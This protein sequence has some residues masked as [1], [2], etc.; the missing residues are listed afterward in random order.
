MSEYGKLLEDLEQLSKSEAD[1]AEE[2]LNKSDE[3]D[4]GEP[5]K[6]I[7]EAAE[8]DDENEGADGDM[9]DDDTDDDDD[10]LMSK[11]LEATLDDGKKA[12]VIDVQDLFKSLEATREN[13]KAELAKS[14]T[15]LQE[16]MEEQG[17]VIKALGEQV[18]R[19]AGA[20]VGRKSV[21]KQP[22]Q[23]SEP[24]AA[25]NNNVLAKCERAMSE[26]RLSGYELSIAETYVNRGMAVPQEIINKL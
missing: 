2:N 7:K 10:G 1:D 14:L 24:K 9:D 15:A 3:E 25:D 20:G 18:V 22:L 19:M 8:V 5:D 17:K 26:G 21:V 23:K 16:K 4:G 11:S 12:K 6:K 13:D